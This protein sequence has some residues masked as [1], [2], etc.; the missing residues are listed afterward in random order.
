MK[1]HIQPQSVGSA[2][3]QH[4]PW[5]LPGFVVISLLVH[6]S[7]LLF[8]IKPILQL[9]EQRFGAT[10][11]STV[12][13]PAKNTPAAPSSHTAIPPTQA[14]I[15]KAKPFH[16]EA[17]ARISQQPNIL[18]TE[19]TTHAIT[20]IAN[21][22]LPVAQP[23]IARASVEHASREISEN[24]E[25]KE[26]PTTQ[27]SLTRQLTQQRN[28]LL[29]ELQNRLKQYLTYPLRA[30]K[31]GWQGEVTVAFYIKEGGL[32]NN[33]RLTKSSGYSVLDR[34][35]LSA[36]GK[37]KHVDLPDRLGRLQAMEM[38]LPVSYQLHEG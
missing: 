32:L 21:R 4:V 2:H 28:Y 36:I 12:L 30:R 6:G 3:F 29:G 16:A 34:S 15:E 24:P 18:A 10:V 1:F 20:T 26:S 17:P 13:A 7:T 14:K 9:P 19:K 23:T 27:E 33:I 35:A 37:L 8:P 38:K 5:L 31:R 22:A 11:I 25:S